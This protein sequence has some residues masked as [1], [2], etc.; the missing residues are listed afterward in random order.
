MYSPTV[1]LVNYFNL[2]K[3]QEK[4][5]GKLPVKVDEAT[6]WEIVQVYL[7]G[8]W[9]VKTPSSV[10]TL[11]CFTAIDPATSILFPQFT[12][13]E[14]SAALTLPSVD[15]VFCSHIMPGKNQALCSDSRLKALFVNILKP[16][17]VETGVW[18]CIP[19]DLSHPEQGGSTDCRCCLRVFTPAVLTLE[20][21]LLPR[22]SA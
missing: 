4:Q 17:Y 12:F 8:P 18:M 10:K 3:K 15:Y 20:G 2:I 11:R 9:K 14:H 13:L 7:I 21:A 6:P 22:S 1:R 5:Y 19:L 16:R